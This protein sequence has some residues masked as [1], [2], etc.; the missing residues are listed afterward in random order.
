MP[1]RFFEIGDQDETSPEQDILLRK[2]A[3]PRLVVDMGQRAEVLMNEFGGK[4][5]HSVDDYDG[6]TLRKEDLLSEAEVAVSM[7]SIETEW[8]T[9]L[10]RR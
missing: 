3:L 1:R 9:G 5:Y 10:H 4:Y 7:S 8:A 2:R 6:S